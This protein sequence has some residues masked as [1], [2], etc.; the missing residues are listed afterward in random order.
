MRNLQ[1]VKKKMKRQQNKRIK[2]P[3]YLSHTC[4]D[5]GWGKFTYEHKNLD[6]DGNPICLDCPFTENRRRIRSERACDKWKVK[7]C[8]N[9]KSAK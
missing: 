7:M 5:C 2:S 4:G 6:L 9:G 8:K 3:V 1:N